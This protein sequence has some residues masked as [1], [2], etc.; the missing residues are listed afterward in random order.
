MT[1]TVFLIRAE[2]PNVPTAEVHSVSPKVLCRLSSRG[3]SFRL[4]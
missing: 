1:I 2:K 4:P 3:S